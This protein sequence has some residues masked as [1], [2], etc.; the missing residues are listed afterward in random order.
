MLLGPVGANGNSTPEV[1]MSSGG[2]DFHGGSA[3]TL[4]PEVKLIFQAITGTKT[5][6]GTDHPD[7]RD[8]AT[9]GKT[10]SDIINSDTTVYVVFDPDLKIEGETD[11]TSAT[12]DA[13]IVARINTKYSTGKYGDYIDLRLTL[14]H[15][16]VHASQAIADPK[17]FRDKSYYSVYKREYQAYDTTARFTA[18][19]QGHYILAVPG[20]PKYFLEKQRFNAHSFTYRAFIHIA[21]QKSAERFR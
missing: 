4:S 8:T 6:A 19:R 21:A 2:T 14:V 16:L 18:E 13:T 3:D 11:F 20:V 1:T 15:E 7:L 10:V 9:V 17:G 12:S 5:I